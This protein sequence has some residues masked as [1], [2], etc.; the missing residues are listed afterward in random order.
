MLT[1]QVGPP[2]WCRVDARVGNGS[3]ARRRSFEPGGDRGL[4]EETLRRSVGI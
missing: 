3:H 4:K 1:G 2:N